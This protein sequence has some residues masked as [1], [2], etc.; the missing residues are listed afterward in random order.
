MKGHPLA[1][2]RVQLVQV[3]LSA[4]RMLGQTALRLCLGKFH[5]AICNVRVTCGE[6]QGN[7]LSARIDIFRASVAALAVRGRP[8]LPQAQHFVGGLLKLP[9]SE[10]SIAAVYDDCDL[11]DRTLA[12]ESEAWLCESVQ[13]LTQSLCVCV[14][15]VGSGQ[16]F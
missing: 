11:T 6:I 2:L 1:T 3:A 8:R 16:R 12:D 14:C 7:A 15:C 5:L 13:A 4:C 9:G 10:V